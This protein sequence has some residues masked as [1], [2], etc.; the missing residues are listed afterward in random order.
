MVFCGSLLPLALV[1]DLKPTND[2][3]HAQALITQAQ[4]VA[5]PQRLYADA[6]YDAE[7]LHRR[8]REEWGVA[9]VIQPIQ[10]RADG[11]RGGKWRSQMSSDYLQQ[12]QY[13]RRWAVESFF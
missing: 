6:G 2:C 10:R 11:Q 13:H 3:T 1:V 12:A 5:Q 4:K 8:C 9:S 7:G